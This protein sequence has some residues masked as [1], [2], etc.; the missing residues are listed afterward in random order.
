M[1][2]VSRHKVFAR[3]KVLAPTVSAEGTEQDMNDLQRTRLSRCCMIW[4]LP[5][6][7][8]PVPPPSSATVSKLSLFLSLS[9]CRWSSLL[10]TAGGPNHTTAREA[11]RQ[12]T[13][14]P[15]SFLLG[16]ESS[17]CSFISAPVLNYRYLISC[18]R[19]Y[20]LLRTV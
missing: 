15:N 17:L 11:E 2:K 16:T 13:N 8:P 4:L 14:F 3:H 18:N 9:L 10:N 1:K 6:P 5:P 12:G 20:H 7:P 19:T